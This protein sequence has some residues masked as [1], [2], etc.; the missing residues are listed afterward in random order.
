MIITGDARQVLGEIQ[1]DPRRT[2]VITDP[3][4]PNPIPELVGSDDPLGLFCEAAAHF[5]RIAK[6]V[7]VVLGVHSDPRFL[8]AIPKEL[9]FIAALRLRY[10]VPKR[11]GRTLVGA[12]IAYAFG[13]M[14][15]P[16]RNPPELCPCECHWLPSR[17]QARAIG[18]EHP[19][20]HPCSRS[21]GHM[22]WLI[23]H[24]TRP[25]DLVLDPFCGVGTTLWAARR[26]WRDALGI[27]IVP[28][29]AARGKAWL[30]AQEDGITLQEREAGQQVLWGGDA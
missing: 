23:E 26:Y 29:F 9:P 14:P 4:W 3:V 25:G 28:E 6:R 11:L 30:A 20:G 18:I 13:R 7:I 22:L 8:S 12:D 24:W 15:E 19:G 27:E 10:P 17:Y 1:A 2:V 21:V 5:P 16:T